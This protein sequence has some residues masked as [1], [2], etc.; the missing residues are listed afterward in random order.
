MSVT[1]LDPCFFM[2][3]Q[4]EVVALDCEMVGVGPDGETSSAASVTLIDWNGNILF[5]S[6]IRQTVPVTDYR[7]FVSGITKEDL[8]DDGEHEELNK[9]KR[10]NLL[11]LEECQAIISSC[12]YNRILVGHGVYN[13]LRVLGITTHPWWLI[14]DTAQFELFMW[15]K[16]QHIRDNNKKGNKK[17]NKTIIFF[18]R[19]LKHLAKEQLKR[20]IQIDG[21]PHSAY[22]DALAALD[23]YRTVCRRWEG[24]I[25]LQ[26]QQTQT[27]YPN[28]NKVIHD[29]AYNNGV[30]LC[31]PYPMLPPQHQQQQQP[32]LN[33]YYN[34]PPSSLMIQQ[35]PLNNLQQQYNT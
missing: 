11:S 4:F 30:N 20:D 22:E 17:N 8:V 1:Q 9:S 5:Q 32:G 33:I 10:M 7:T 35:Q 31:L 19:K 16:C 28:Y 14:R 3:P 15:S 27:K 25:T 6:Y 29:V 26:W 24:M 12:L 21:Q 34:A 18:P 23:L 13:D 2:D